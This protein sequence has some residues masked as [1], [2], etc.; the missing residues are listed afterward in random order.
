[1]SP[2]SN[3]KAVRVNVAAGNPSASSLQNL[4]VRPIEANGS[5]SDSSEEIPEFAYSFNYYLPSQSQFI[6]TEGKGGASM[7]KKYDLDFAC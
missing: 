7:S 3:Y 1:M 5:E 6:F 4:R 2:V